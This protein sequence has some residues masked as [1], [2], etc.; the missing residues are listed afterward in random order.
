MLPVLLVLTCVVPLSLLGLV[1]PLL[2]LLTM[3]WR[4]LGPPRP[5]INPPP[6]PAA[7]AWG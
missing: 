2:S 5:P 4:R 7:A 3:P 6:S 1:V